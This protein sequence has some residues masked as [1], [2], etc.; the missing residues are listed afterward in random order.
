[1][2]YLLPNQMKNKF[3]KGQR[4]M[5]DTKAYFNNIPE[6]VEVTI[7]RKRS[8]WVREVKFDEEKGYLHTGIWI[9]KRQDR[10][11][12]IEEFINIIDKE[13]EQHKAADIINELTEKHFGIHL[14]TCWKCWNIISVEKED[15]D[16]YQCNCCKTFMEKEH[17]PD[18][19]Y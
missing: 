19:F 10:Y 18:L 15:K 3:K 8:E 9:N 7:M 16:M 4:V 17:C 11:R 14:V 6:L 5:V 2:F 12:I 13:V 1:M